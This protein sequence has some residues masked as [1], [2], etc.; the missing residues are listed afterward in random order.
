[1]TIQYNVNRMEENVILTQKGNIFTNSL[2]LLF[3]LVHQK[4][5]QIA[6]KVRC[7]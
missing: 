7:C 2:I 4:K 5:C 1:M 3:I 6:K